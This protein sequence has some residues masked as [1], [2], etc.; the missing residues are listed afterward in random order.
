[1]LIIYYLNCKMK[2]PFESFKST[3]ASAEAAASTADS[4]S[5]DLYSCNPE[6]L[7]NVFE[8]ISHNLEKLRSAHDKE[9]RYL[10]TKIFKLGRA[11][12]TIQRVEKAL[13]LL[14]C[15]P[16]A[17]SSLQRTRVLNG[18]QSIMVN[19]FYETAMTSGP[20]FGIEPDSD[21]ESDSSDCC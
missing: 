17:I 14:T 1:M 6:N 4:T 19:N 13:E 21:D 8:T 5:E 16:I 11:K 7:H 12:Q 10:K 15:S 18:I 2:S 9:E 20:M 3:T